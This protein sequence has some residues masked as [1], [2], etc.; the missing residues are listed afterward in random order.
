MRFATFEEAEA[1]IRLISAPFGPHTDAEWHKLA[2][3][4]L[5][6]NADGEWIRHYD[7][8]LAQPF[9]STSPDAFKLS[10]MLLWKAY[11]AITCPTLLVRGAESDLLSAETARQMTQSGP[12]AKLAELAGVGHAPTFLHID[13]IKIVT[14]FLIG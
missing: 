4:V 11:Q 13:Q 7:L 6:Q 3:D 9:I 12:K 14:D 8:K 5:H 2:S 10:E 1:Y